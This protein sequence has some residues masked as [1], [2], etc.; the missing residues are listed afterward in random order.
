MRHAFI[1]A[2]GSWVQVEPSPQKGWGL[3]ETHSESLTK[4]VQRLS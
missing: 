2:G 1:E 3:L 4:T